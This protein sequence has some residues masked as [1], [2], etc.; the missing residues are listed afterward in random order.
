M[1]HFLLIL[2]LFGFFLT[3]AQ[4]ESIDTLNKVYI[5]DEVWKA[6][7][8]KRFQTDGYPSFLSLENGNVTLFSRSRDK[9]FAYES[10]VLELSI[11]VENNRTIIQ[12]LGERPFKTPNRPSFEITE[13][14]N[15]DTIIHVFQTL[16]GFDTYFR[17]HIASENEVNKLTEYLKAQ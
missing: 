9:R 14:E 16:G 11:E 13:S 6:G 17:A 15:D 5:L 8:N 1:K 2:F 3:K 4:T 7:E 10:F 12:F